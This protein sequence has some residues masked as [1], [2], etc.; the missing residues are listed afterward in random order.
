[1]EAGSVPVLKT[2]CHWTRCKILSCLSPLK[3]VYVSYLKFTAAKKA[4]VYLYRAGSV[5]IGDKAK[6]TAPDAI[7]S[8]GVIHSIDTVLIPPSIEKQLA[9]IMAKTA[10]KQKKLIG[11]NK[12]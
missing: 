12:D 1:M 10:K 7:G 4:Q 9:K 2:V 3:K 11:S 8:N 6:V 5:V